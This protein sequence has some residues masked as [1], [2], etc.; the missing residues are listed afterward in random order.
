MTLKSS[1][2]WDIGDFSIRLQ[3]QVGLVDWPF[4]Q[5][6]LGLEYRIINVAK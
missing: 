5:I 1:A 3:H 2:S 4:H 6:R